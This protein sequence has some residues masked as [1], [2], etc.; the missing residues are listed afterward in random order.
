MNARQGQFVFP[1]V[2]KNNG[3]SNFGLGQP[4]DMIMQNY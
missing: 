1:R 3:K 2:R 4:V